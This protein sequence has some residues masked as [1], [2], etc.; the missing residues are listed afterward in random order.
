MRANSRWDD[1]IDWLDHVV[2]RKF[3]LV[4]LKNHRIETFFYRDWLID[5][6]KKGGRM[7]KGEKND[8]LHWDKENKEENESSGEN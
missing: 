4:R 6:A 5:I 1:F 7:T 8:V 2:L 3:G